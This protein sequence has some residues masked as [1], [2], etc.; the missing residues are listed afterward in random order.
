MAVL[1]INQTVADVFA[2]KINN[3]R[4]G[5]AYLFIAPKGAGKIDTA[6]AIA[7]AINCLANKGHACGQ[8]ASCLKVE[9]GNHPDVTVIDSNSEAIKID[10]IRGLLNKAQY[11]AYEA[12]CKVF[13]IA[14]CELM[15]IEAANAFLKTLEEPAKDTLIILTTSA[16]YDVLDTIKSRCQWIHFAASS[17]ANVAA[18]LIESGADSITADYLANYANGWAPLAQRLWRDGFYA[19]KNELVDALIK[20]FSDDDIK[21]WADEKPQALEALDIF[22]SL[23]RDAFVYQATQNDV[24]LINRDNAGKVKILAQKSPQELEAVGRLLKQIKHQINENLNPKMAFGI[25]KE[26]LWNPS[27]R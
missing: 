8:C 23:V 3:D 2:Q 25:L 10:Q 14:D 5:H 7:R 17:R 4:L 1:S 16:P 22:M 15:T 26:S 19:R 11:R 12:R 20:G 18:H 13:I 21:M 27:S 6:L 9:H 24:L